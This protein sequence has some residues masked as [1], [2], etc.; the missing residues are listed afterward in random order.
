MKRVIFIDI[1]KLLEMLENKDH[2]WLVDARSEKHFKEGHIP[3]AINLPLDNI[4]KTAPKNLKKNDK[5]VVYCGN[6]ECP[7][8][9]EATKIL[10]ELGYKKVFDFKAGADG[11]ANAELEL[12]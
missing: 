1:E 6:Y 10:L 7:V 8:N 11:W 12:E 4:R 5:I 3:G 2:F 9:T